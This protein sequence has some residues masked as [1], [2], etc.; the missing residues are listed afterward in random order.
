MANLSRGRDA[1][2]KGLSQQKSA[3]CRQLFEAAAKE[4]LHFPWLCGGRVMDFSFL[5]AKMS[6]EQ[7][8]IKRT[9]GGRRK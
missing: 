3:S 2:L 9:T 5:R 1:K 4:R 8:K 6:V 7:P